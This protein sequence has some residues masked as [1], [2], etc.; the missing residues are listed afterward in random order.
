MEQI[1]V[2]PTET[3]RRVGYFQGFCDQPQR[4]LDQLLRPEWMSFRPRDE[5]EKDPSFKQLIPYVI[6][7]HRPPAEGPRLF[8]YLRGKGQG[9]RR[10]HSKR[11]V[12]VGGHIS[13]EDVAGGRHENV[14]LAGMQRELDEEVRIEVAHELKCVGLINDDETEVGTVHLGIVHICDVKEPL[15]FAR[16]DDI[17][18][19]G[20]VPLPQLLSRLDEFESWSRICLE[21]LFA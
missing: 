5:M 13:S 12:G 7:R 9:E 18:D 14:Y 4:Y 8:S 3:F 21:A 10:L 16:E 19:A 1:L 17:A 20:F 15:V 11:S 2:V 6:F